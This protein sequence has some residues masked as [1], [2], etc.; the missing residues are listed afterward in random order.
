[1]IKRLIFTSVR[2]QMW[3]LKKKKNFLNSG[4]IKDRLVE[5]EQE[6]RRII[7]KMKNIDLNLYGDYVRNLNEI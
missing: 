3:K 5:H 1:M 7:K 2:K 4:K 6:N